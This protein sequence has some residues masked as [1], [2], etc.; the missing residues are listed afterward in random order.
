LSHVWLPALFYAWAAACSVLS[1]AVQVTSMSFVYRASHRRPHFGY[2]R[3]I[4]PAAP[5]FSASCAGVARYTLA[6]NGGR[7]T[8]K[9]GFDALSCRYERSGEIREWGL[10]HDDSAAASYTIQQSTDGSTWQQVLSVSGT[11]ANSY[12]ATGPFNGSTTYYFRVV[13]YSYTGGYSAYSSTA[14]ATTPAFPARPTLSTATAQSD[15]AVVLAWGDVAGESGFRVD[16]STDNG[17]TWVAAGTVGAGVTSFT[18]TGLAETTSYVYRVAATNAAGSS[19]PSLTRSVATQPSAPT[20]L[21]ATAVSPT[22]IK[23]VVGRPLGVGLLLLHRSIGRRGDLD[24]G[25]FGVR[26]GIELLHGDGAVQRRGDVL[27]PGPC[28]CLPRGQLGLRHGV[29]DDTGLPEP[30]DLE[31]GHGSVDTAVALSWTAAAGAT[32][33]RVERFDRLQRPPGRRR[34]RSAPA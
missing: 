34:A 6:M 26:H 9:K 22:Q 18:D 12:S 4:R 14:S 2:Q 23:P 30:A 24:P 16:R 20:G 17:T 25:R 33:Y 29:G 8:L 32:G 27:F 31:R 11:G 5:E 13:A 21:A 7:R 3:S 19:A 28:L 1:F 15:T 10:A